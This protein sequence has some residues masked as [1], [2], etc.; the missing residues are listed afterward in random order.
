MPATTTISN[1]VRINLL[2]VV[3]LIL[4]LT[5]MPDQLWAADSHV[6]CAQ[7]E[8]QLPEPGEETPEEPVNEHGEDASDTFLQTYSN[9]FC[10]GTPGQSLRI[11]RCAWSP[12]TGIFQKISPPPRR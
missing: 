2:R 9:C 12:L 5:F 3:C 4:A 10:S 1:I 8:E 11:I 6:S 7:S